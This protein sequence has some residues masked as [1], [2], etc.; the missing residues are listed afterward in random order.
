MFRQL[1]ELAAQKG[2][3][4]IHLVTGEAPLL[5]VDGRLAR[6]NLPVLTAEGFREWLTTLLPAGQLEELG[7]K[8]EL[9]TAAS[10]ASLR[11]RLNIYRRL[12]GWAAAIR[13]LPQRVPTLEELGLPAGLTV[14]AEQ[15]Q[16]LLLVTGPTGSGKSTTLAACIEHLNRTR[17]LHIITIE[18]PVE[19]RHVNRRALINQR[20]VGRDTESFAS[21]LRAALRQDPDVILVGEMRD[22]T[23]I[24]TAL[25]AAE[26]GHLV[27]STLH[28]A[29]A[30]QTVDRI[31]DVFPAHQQPQVRSQLAGVL[32]GI[33]AQRLLPRQTGSGRVAALEILVATP[34][35]RNLIREGK[36]FQLPSVI[37]AGRQT[38]MQAL[39][40]SL[41]RLYQAGRVAYE[42]ALAAANDQ[43]LFVQ[44][45][46]AGM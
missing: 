22:L 32:A 8:G 4:D 20:E 7:K 29:S 34:A 39:E 9:D 37:Q 36:T 14:L 5:R 40:H 19:Y 3:S 24:A 46:R 31:I 6:T 18:D 13:L 17:D 44:L 25:T 26:T 43:A 42:E 28:T 10:T 30:A 12:G 33:V 15:R 16:G 2:A 21:G 27:L 41:T 11:L 38:G 35:V 45:A 1:L 23:T